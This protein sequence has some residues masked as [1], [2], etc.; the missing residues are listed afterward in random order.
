MSA[1]RQ[2]T[3]LIYELNGFLHVQWNTLFMVRDFLYI[4]KISGVAVRAETLCMISKS[5]T[6]GVAEKVSFKTK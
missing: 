4:S 3:S 1:S 5:H 6:M 2:A